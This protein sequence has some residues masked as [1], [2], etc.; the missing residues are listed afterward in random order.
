MSSREQTPRVR[1]TPVPD[2]G[3]FVRG[4]ELDPK[5]LADDASR[6]RERFS[7]WARFGISAFHASS[8]DEIDAICQTRLVR[9]AIVVVFARADLESAGIEVVPTFRT[10]H[11][12][13]CHA[14]LDQ[15][16]ERL[17]HCE[18]AERSNPYHVGDEGSDQW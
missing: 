5:L 16:I 2:G 11:V 14:D 4:D 13:L 9:F 8:E 1:L 17:V 12:T 15:L 10:P 3:V 6:F 7:E 18:H